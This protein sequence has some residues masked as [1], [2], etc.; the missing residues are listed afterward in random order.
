MKKLLLGLCSLFLVMAASA[1]AKTLPQALEQARAEHRQVLL[2]FSG[3]DWC[4]PCI[5]MEKE[6]FSDSLFRHYAHD[7]LVELSADFP[8][9]KKHQLSKEQRAQNELLAARYNPQG[10]FPLVLL[11]DAD[12]NVLRRWTGEGKATP[13][14]FLEQL[15]SLKAR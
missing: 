12:G 4:I 15:A 14:G 7:N 6:V 1:Q 2:R 10:E 11:L 3:S 9:L 13:A 5:R 8:R